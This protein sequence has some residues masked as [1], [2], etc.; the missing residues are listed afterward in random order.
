MLI[1]WRERKTGD[2]TLSQTEVRKI[3]HYH[4]KRYK[5]VRRKKEDKGN[6]DVPER[7]VSGPEGPK[8]RKI[9][10]QAFLPESYFRRG[11]LR[12]NLHEQSDTSEDFP[13]QLSHKP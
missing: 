11:S 10:T 9:E 8:K 1:C 3:V 6:R 13:R 4:E 7:A 2:Y 5:K 12:T